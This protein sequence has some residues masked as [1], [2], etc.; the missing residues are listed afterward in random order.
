MFF[1]Y[2]KVVFK[3]EDVR[4]QTQYEFVNF[5]EDLQVGDVVLVKLNRESYSGYS[6]AIATV[7]QID[8]K[9]KAATSY[10]IERIDDLD[11]QEKM[12]QFNKKKEIEEKMRILYEKQTSFELYRRIAEENQE[13]KKL[14]EEYESL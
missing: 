7:A 14:L 2:V 3:N 13:M 9:G 6:V 8:T 11:A 10:V 5:I 4:G 1:N 12:K